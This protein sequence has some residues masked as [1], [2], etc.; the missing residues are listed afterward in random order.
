MGGAVKSA[1]LFG[2]KVKCM[3]TVTKIGGKEILLNEDAIE[4]AYETPD[5]VIVMTN[6]HTYIVMETVN[7]IIEKT[8]EY[9]QRASKKRLGRD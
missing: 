6:G 3:I 4:S 9:R 5:T 8:L 7:E 2:T 1:R